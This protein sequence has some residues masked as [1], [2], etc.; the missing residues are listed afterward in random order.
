MTR[1]GRQA[2]RCGGLV[3]LAGFVAA[4]ASGQQNVRLSNSAEVPAARGTVSS[5]IAENGNTKFDIKVEHLAPPNKVEASASTYVVW[6]KPLET[7]EPAQ[8]VGAL[9]VDRQRLTGTFEGITSHRRFQLSITA[10]SQTTARNPSGSKVLSAM[11]LQ[12]EK[13]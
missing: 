7:N 8:N 5:K 11:V 13:S 12:P 1:H 6:L 3:A 2:T 9:R 10:E 4:C